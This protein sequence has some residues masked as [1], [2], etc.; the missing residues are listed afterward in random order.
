MPHFAVRE[1]VRLLS[2]RFPLLVASSRG[3]SFG[4][5]LLPGGLSSVS[6]YPLTIVHSDFEP[7]LF[8]FDFNADPAIYK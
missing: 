5:G 4:C 8:T 1:R 3:F 7:L 2:F 6:V